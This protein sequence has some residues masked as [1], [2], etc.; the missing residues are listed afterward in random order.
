MSVPLVGPP[1]W[2]SGASTYSFEAQRKPKRETRWTEKVAARPAVRG[3][4]VRARISAP[5]N[6]AVP[7]D[8]DADHA[9]PRST[10]AA[11]ARDAIGP[12]L[13]ARRLYGL[14][15]LG[16]E[17][18]ASLRF[19][20]ARDIRVAAAGLAREAPTSCTSRCPTAERSASPTRR[21]S[22]PSPVRSPAVRLSVVMPCYNE[23]ATIREIVSRVLAVDLPEH[24][25]RAGHRR[26]WVD[27]RDA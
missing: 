19:A 24:R 1:R 23:R 22:R 10:S 2:P 18:G 6:E 5:W 16:G 7:A 8:G 27:R 14:A 9:P 4:Q 21:R 26:R 25:K 15:A 17:L 13:H 12:A 3:R 20:Q 11:Q